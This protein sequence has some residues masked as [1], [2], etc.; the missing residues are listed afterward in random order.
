MLALALPVGP[1]QAQG[2][3]QV[4]KQRAAEIDQAATQVQAMLLAGGTP[5]TDAQNARLAIRATMIAAQYHGLSGD[6]TN[7][8]AGNVLD[9]YIAPQGDQRALT[10]RD[11]QIASAIAAQTAT[12][13]RPKLPTQDADA[14]IYTARAA[15]NKAI[16][17]HP[18]SPEAAG[19]SPNNP[20]TTNLSDLTDLDR[21]GTLAAW[22]VTK[23]FL[24]LPPLGDPKSPF[25]P[26]N[27]LA[28]GPAPQPSVAAAPPP[29]P[30]QDVDPDAITVTT[31][32]GTVIVSKTDGD[33]STTLTVIEQDLN[34]GQN[35]NQGNSKN[36]TGND[37]GKKDNTAGNNNSGGN[38]SNHSSGGH[39][40]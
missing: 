20:M 37:G 11:R 31:D 12:I 19:I 6:V 38:N 22:D 30:S 1:A 9:A 2:G 13:V 18:E 5:A 39:H 3:F 32:T 8:L 27:T 7:A 40:K 14:I 25:N 16:L 35:N 4:T 28:D 26:A 21:A 33:G 34:A 29:D 17:S 15:A 24:P 36:R 23:P 10:D